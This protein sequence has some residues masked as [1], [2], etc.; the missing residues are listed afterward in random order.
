MVKWS[1]E[2]TVGVYGRQSAKFPEI[3]RG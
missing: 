1:L 3:T 2:R